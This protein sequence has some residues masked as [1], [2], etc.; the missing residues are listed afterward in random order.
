MIRFTTYNILDGGQDREYLIT[1][2]LAE[3]DS[4]IILL[5]EVMCPEFVSSLADKFNMNYFVALGNTNRHQAI[6]SK[7][8]IQAA[9]SIHP[10]PPVLKTI[11]HAKIEYVNNLFIN[12]IGIHLVPHPQIL[13]E[14]WRRWELIPAF[15]LSNQHKNEPCIMAGDFN[16]FAPGDNVLVERMPNYLK[17]M[18][19]LQGNHICRFAINSVLKSGFTDCY[20]SLNSSDGFTLPAHLPNARLDYIFTNPILKPNLSSCIVGDKLKYSTKASDHL[21]LIAEFSI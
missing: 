17:R 6:L 15:N 12:V 14:I 18:I 1:E 21:P 8:P 4:D 2:N 20:R 7:F 9:K 5:Q 3:I 16:T 10:F 13:L 19:A 11:L